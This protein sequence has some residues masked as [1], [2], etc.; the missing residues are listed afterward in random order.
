MKKRATVTALKRKQIRCD[1]EPP[2]NM[3]NEER[4]SMDALL[5]RAEDLR[6]QIKRN[7]YPTGSGML[8]MMKYKKISLERLLKKTADELAMLNDG[9]AQL[10]ANPGLEAILS[11]LGK[12][13]II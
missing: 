1:S 6:R 5:E 13:D 11:A 10:E 8:D 4:S 2:A 12:A 9:I 7:G 3:N